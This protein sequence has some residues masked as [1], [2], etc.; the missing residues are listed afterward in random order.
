M[1][2][3]FNTIFKHFIIVSFIIFTALYISQ[4]SGYYEYKN[5]KKVALTNQQIKQFEKDVSEGKKVN[6]KK[7]TE[8]NNKNYQN[9]MSKT[10]LSISSISEKII[11]KIINETFKILS[12]VMGE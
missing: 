10:G 2:D 9:K 6:I 5:K 1:E 7:Y 4:A 12:K 3:K 8:I 11:Q